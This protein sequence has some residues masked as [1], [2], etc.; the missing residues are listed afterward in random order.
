MFPSQ[1]RIRHPK[2][3][4]EIKKQIA[5]FCGIQSRVGQLPSPNPV[6]L[7]RQHLPLL[8]ERDYV[9]TEKAD[10]VFFFL[11]LSRY[12]YSAN[13][14]FAVMIDRSWQ[15]FQLEI[16]APAEAFDGTLFYGELVLNDK[17]QM[18]NFLVYGVW[19]YHGKGAGTL[20]LM[21]R[22]EL[23]SQSFPS[24]DEWNI[25]TSSERI[26]NIAQS[27][28]ILVVP[29]KERT[30]FIY[31][32]AQLPLREF[33]ALTRRSWNH[34]ID[35]YIFTPINIPETHGSNDHLF[36]FKFHPTVDLSFNGTNYHCQ[37][38]DTRVNICDAF[39]EVV[40]QFVL[41]DEYHGKDRSVILEMTVELIS[42]DSYVCKFHKKREDKDTPNQKKTIAAILHEVHQKLS[43]AELVRLLDSH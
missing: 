15:M 3:Y 37:E 5:T 6:C 33:G 4:G 32:K 1:H 10:G 7:L 39:P 29:E 40:F 17:T 14:P 28:K 9:V 16:L 20:N 8:V 11:L 12:S 30:L 24:Q 26:N 41:P 2:L 42:K 34:A 13:H 35:G 36:K 21:Q 23:I 43:V 38:V 25:N 27:G 31:A 22:Y 18:L 19:Y